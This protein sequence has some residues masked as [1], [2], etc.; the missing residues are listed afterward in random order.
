[1][2]LSPSSRA[3]QSG[4]DFVISPLLEGAEPQETHR[5]G[6]RTSIPI[7]LSWEGQGGDTV[8]GQEVE[9]RSAA[10]GGGMCCLAH[11][12]CITTVSTGLP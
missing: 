4:V 2:S 10:V 12:T 8:T 11:A 3:L 5:V 6:D 7:P 1:M 9:P